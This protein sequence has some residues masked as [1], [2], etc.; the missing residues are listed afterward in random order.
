[1]PKYQWKEDFKNFPYG[2][3]LKVSYN[4]KNFLGLAF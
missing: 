3:D 2:E 4:L 1:M